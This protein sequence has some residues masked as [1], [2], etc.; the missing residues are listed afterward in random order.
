[1]ARLLLVCAL[2]CLLLAPGTAEAR[3]RGW[4]QRI[5]AALPWS[6]HARQVRRLHRNARQGRHRERRARLLLRL[7][8][9]LSS[10]QAQPYLVDRHNRPLTDP[11]SGRGRR[12]D[13]AVIS[14]F[15]RVQALV[16]VTSRHADKR[17]QQ[18]KTRRIMARHRK[19]YV[20]DKRSSSPRR[21]RRGWL[22]PTRLRTL[23]L[24]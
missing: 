15:G 16:E 11:H 7:R 1:M 12:F 18:A 17:A 10:I 14:P 5:A 20:L 21:V 3:P 23:R 22:L 6:H 24:R 13:Y 8:Y 2:S 19:V 9:P 4:L